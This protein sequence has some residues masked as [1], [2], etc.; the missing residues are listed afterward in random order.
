MIYEAVGAV[1]DVESMF[2]PCQQFIDDL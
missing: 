1:W 2:H